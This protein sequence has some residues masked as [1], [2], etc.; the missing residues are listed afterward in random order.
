LTIFLI[1]WNEIFCQKYKKLFDAN[2][3]G[4]G[5]SFYLQSKV[6]R[7]KEVLLKELQ[8]PSKEDQDTA[9]ETPVDNKNEQ[10][11]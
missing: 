1:A 10:Q 3:P 8:E 11:K 4:K 2:D 6:F 7:S 5:G 9:A